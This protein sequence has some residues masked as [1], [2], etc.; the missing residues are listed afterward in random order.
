MRFPRINSYPG[1]P[2]QE[3]QEELQILPEYLQQP[4]Y[5]SVSAPPRSIISSLVVGTIERLSSS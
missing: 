3:A 4:I 2:P 5:S 1:W